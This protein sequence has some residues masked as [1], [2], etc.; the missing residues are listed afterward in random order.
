MADISHYG[1]RMLNVVSPPLVAPV[2]VP[3]RT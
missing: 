2:I 1:V 3:L